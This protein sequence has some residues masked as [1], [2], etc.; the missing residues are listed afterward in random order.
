MQCGVPF[1]MR[2][3]SHRASNDIDLLPTF[4]P[5]MRI[6]LLRHHIDNLQIITPFLD[7]AS[8][9]LQ[10]FALNSPFSSSLEL[11]DTSANIRRD[12][13]NNLLAMAKH[14]TLVYVSQS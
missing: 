3:F 10:A 14:R 6:S 1:S 8:F 9:I 11:H 13:E 4:S 2:I 7:V 5:F 12:D